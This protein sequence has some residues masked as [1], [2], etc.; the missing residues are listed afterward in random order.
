MVSEKTREFLKRVGFVVDG[1]YMHEKLA[2]IKCSM[3][4]YRSRIFAMNWGKVLKALKLEGIELVMEIY[5]GKWLFKKVEGLCES[6]EE[7][8]LWEYL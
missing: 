1:V 7:A 3:G 4:V 6:E 2:H 5:Y 8:S